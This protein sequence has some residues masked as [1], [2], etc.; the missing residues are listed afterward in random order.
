MYC[1]I[2]IYNCAGCRVCLLYHS[3]TLGEAPK[4]FCS[5]ASISVCPTSSSR[6]DSSPWMSPSTKNLE[7]RRQ[8]SLVTRGASSA[9]MALPHEL[10][11]HN[12]LAISWARKQT[13]S[14]SPIPSGRVCEDIPFLSFPFLSFRTLS[15]PVLGR[16]CD[17]ERVIGATGDDGPVEWTTVLEVAG[18]RIYACCSLHQ[19]NAYFQSMLHYLYISL[20][21]PSLQ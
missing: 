15:E 2:F 21:L 20:V 1:N 19:T 17:V 3:R 10:A 16:N 18:Q 12:C 5:C 13:P 11:I 8:P 14:V 7:A 9:T 4:C 6:L